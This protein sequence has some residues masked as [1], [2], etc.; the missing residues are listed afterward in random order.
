[1]ATAVQWQ[2]V[3]TL[4]FGQTGQARRRTASRAATVRSS[5]F[6]STSAL[7]GAQS[8]RARALRSTSAHR[9]GG[10]AIQFDPK[11]SVGFALDESPTGERQRRLTPG[12]FRLYGRG[13]PRPLP[14]SVRTCLA[15]R[16]C[17]WSETL[18]KPRYTSFGLNPQLYSQTQSLR[19]VDMKRVLR[20][21]V[22]TRAGAVCSHVPLDCTDTVN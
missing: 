1:M 19:S 3:P 14:D 9:K 4:D 20:S 5:V 18:T 8:T 11:G 6:R 15:S 16:P 21:L 7:R 10:D 12:M 2:R 17:R 22:N 13:V